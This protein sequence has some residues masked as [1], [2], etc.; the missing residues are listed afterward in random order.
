MRKAIQVIVF[1]YRVRE[2]DLL[3]YA[4]FQR[5]DDPNIWQAIAGGSEDSETPIE[6]ARRETE[7][8]ASISQTSEFIELDSMSTIPVDL[9]RGF[10]WGSE[11]LVVPQ[12]SFGVDATGMEINL[13]DEHVNVE[14]CSFQKGTE[15]LTFES[16][17]LALWELNHRLTAHR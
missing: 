16:N 9:I 3:E 11:V 1:P 5:S 17:R 8:E 2:S 7:E 6:T 4:I 13:S 10:E 15:L 14:W 12:Y